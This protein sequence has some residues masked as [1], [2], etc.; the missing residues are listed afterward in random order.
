MLPHLNR[1]YRLSVRLVFVIQVPYHVRFNG[2][3]SSRRFT[4]L[5]DLGLLTVEVS[6][7]HSDTRHSVREIVSSQIPLPYN[8]QH[9]NRLFSWTDSNP[10][11]QQSSGRRPTSKIARP[12][13][14]ACD[15]MLSGI[16]LSTLSQ[17]SHFTFRV[18][19]DGNVEV[20]CSIRK[21]IILYHTS[22]QN[23]PGA[24][25]FKNLYLLEVQHCHSPERKI[26]LS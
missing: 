17:D 22:Q 23:T 10:Q 9:S 25:I 21:L 16:K 18:L 7:S 1:F 8:I 3:V 14:S 24:K 4:A 6:I 20:V 11:S 5:L 15:A 26:L 12:L 19:K 13:R 2:Q